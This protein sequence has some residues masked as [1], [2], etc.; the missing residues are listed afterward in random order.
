MCMQNVCSALLLENRRSRA[1]NA[2]DS[3]VFRVS[4]AV[5]VFF[6]IVLHFSLIELKQQAKWTG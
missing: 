3:C 1:F 6:L 5:S 4:G 2:L